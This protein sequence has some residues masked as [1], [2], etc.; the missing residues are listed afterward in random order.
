MPGGNREGVAGSRV[1]HF[2]EGDLDRNHQEERHPRICLSV[3]F[4]GIPRP[5]A[6]HGGSRGSALAPLSSGRQEAGGPGTVPA[7]VRE[8]G[9]AAGTIS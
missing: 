8:I 9:V 1:S 5:C 3:L 2:P 7:A 6:S 4:P